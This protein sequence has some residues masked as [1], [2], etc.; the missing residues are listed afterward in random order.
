MN[1]IVQ[2][3]REGF[4]TRSIALTAALLAVLLACMFGTWRAGRPSIEPFITPNST[5]IVVRTTGF[6][7]TELTYHTTGAPYH[8][9]DVLTRSLAAQG[10]RDINPWRPFG[11]Y[12]TYTYAVSIGPALIRDEIDLHGEA[13]DV[14]LVLRRRFYVRWP[15]PWW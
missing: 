6:G 15:A 3:K 5:N 13:H 12:A 8:W 14:R 4:V 1:S 2:P 7:Q 9:Y 11:Q 10:W